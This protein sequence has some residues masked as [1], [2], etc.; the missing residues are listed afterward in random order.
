MLWFCKSKKLWISIEKKI[1]E[2]SWFCLPKKFTNFHKKSW[3]CCSFVYW[4]NYEFLSRK[5]WKCCGFVCR[6]KLLFFF[7]SWISIQKIVKMLELSLPKKIMKMLRFCLPK[8]IMN[9]HQWISW[10]YAILF[11]E[12]LWIFI[13]KN[14]ENVAG[15]FTEKNYE[16]LYKK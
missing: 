12:K 13:L 7:K 15:F 3:K 16:F 2:M 1:V 11:T 10:K 5:S 4:K 9:F 14:R 6:K 8:K